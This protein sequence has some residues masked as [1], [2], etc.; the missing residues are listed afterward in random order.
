MRQYIF[1][2]LFF[3]SG[4]VFGQLGSEIYLFDLATDLDNVT[5]A[6][7]MNITQR[8]GYDN[9]PHFYDNGKKILFTSMEVDNRTNI[10]SYNTKSGKTKKIFDTSVSEYSPI[11]TH[12]D[13]YF[14][15]IVVEE[16]GDQRLWKYKMNGK[17]RFPVFKNIKFI[18]YHCRIDKQ[19]LALFIVGEPNTLQIGN[20]IT[21]NSLYVTEKIGR[22]M[23]LIPGQKLLTFVH[24]TDS[25]SWMIKSLNP[26]NL[27]MTDVIDTL[28][29]S[30]DFCVLND[31]TFLM[32]QGN[33]LFKYNPKTDIDWSKVADLSNYGINARFNRLT[34]SP[35][36]RKLAIVVME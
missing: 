27:V 30:E 5:I 29:G 3:L 2:I 8:P 35:N 18:G 22:A 21:G 31:G 11:P 16:N 24:K 34:V 32:G 20:T 28:P 23:H 15:C 9:Q 13:K 10:Y 17:A 14:T 26:D 1:F 7:P 4:N 36:N 12:K 19:R 33:A 25:S 6:N